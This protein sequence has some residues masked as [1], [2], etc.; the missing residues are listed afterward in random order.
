MKSP[1]YNSFLVFV[2]VTFLISCAPTGNIAV[3]NISDK[4]P[5]GTESF[6]Y[7]LPQTVID[8][9]VIAEE[10]T[11][12]PG[13]YEKFAEKYLGIQN[14]PSRAEK[15]Y[16]IRQVQVQKHSE[17]DPDYIY[18]VRGILDPANNAGLTRL[19]KDSLILNTANF[20]VSKAYHYTYPSRS[21]ELIYTDLSVK[22]NFE[23]EK[24][25]E[26]SLVMPDTIHTNRP[27]NRNALKEKT[28][29][30]KAEEAANFLIKLKKRRFKLV[31]GQYNYMPAGEAMAEAL[32]ELGR[33]EEE[34][35]S[36]FIGKR[37]V[38]QIQHILHYTPPVGKNA[39]REILF[40]FDENEG[41]VN[42]TEAR[43]IPVILELNAMGKT[44]GLEQYKIPLN[45]EN[46]VLPYRIADQTALR[47]IA[48]EQLWVEA[49]YPVF[50]YGVLVMMNLLER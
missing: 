21:G 24:D 16:Y 23:A 47:L 39:I 25:I 26:V 37:I 20:S 9:Q 18:A 22:R 4:K 3:N 27:V 44:A 10:I 8:I 36:L 35:L 12:I 17:A 49:Y 11:I 28:L 30:Q 31:A 13:P 7:A 6:V 40:R 29:E 41:F 2:A 43:G 14:A 50:Q 38:T 45:L 33:I 34:Y 15:K 19:L 46:N 5:L 1:W 32:K 48:G 42:L